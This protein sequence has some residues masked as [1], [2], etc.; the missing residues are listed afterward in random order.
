MIPLSQSTVFK[1]SIL[2]SGFLIVYF[3]CSSQFW[4]HWWPLFILIGLFVILFFIVIF[5]R[6]LAQCLKKETKC[7]FYYASL[8]INMLAILIVYCLPSNERSKQYYKNTGTLCNYKTGNCG[9]NLY[10]EYYC[11][12]GNGYM[13]TDLNAEYLTDSLTFRKFLGV[14]DEGDEHINII[15]KGDSIIV[16]KTST[17]SI[18][19]RFS[20]PRILEKKSYS[21][22][23]LKKGHTFD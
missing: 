11:V 13:T 4:A 22:K 23:D 2:S 19:L 9:C 1:L 8:W 3:I 15:C 18:D 16:E 21:L 10:A 5:I 14:Y 17:E 20:R 6:S 12:Y 7:D